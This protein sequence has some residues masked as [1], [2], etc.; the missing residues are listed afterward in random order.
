MKLGDLDESGYYIIHGRDIS[1]CIFPDLLVDSYGYTALFKF[2]NE[3]KEL[4]G[5]NIRYGW[6]VFSPSYTEEI[7]SQDYYSIYKISIED[8]NKLIMLNELVK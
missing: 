8:K 1:D 6:L 5:Y 4:R 7:K 2:D 3:N